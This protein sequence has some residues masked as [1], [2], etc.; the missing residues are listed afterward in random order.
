M[1]EIR[2]SAV[3]P[4]CGPSTWRFSGI[5]RRI[6]TG[7]VSVAA[8]FGGVTVHSWVCL[9][10]LYVA[11]ASTLM[12]NA[13]FGSTPGRS[14]GVSDPM[15]SPYT[16]DSLTVGVLVQLAVTSGVSLLLL[17]SRR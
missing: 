15:S 16:N 5:G 13:E 10:S 11:A 6:Q 7:A 14:A 12:L 2:N 8:G 1:P 3:A 17:I 9:P 4:L